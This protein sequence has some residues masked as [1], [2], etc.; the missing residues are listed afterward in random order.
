MDEYSIDINLLGLA[1]EALCKV[2][3]FIAAEKKKKNP[4]TKTQHPDRPSFKAHDLPECYSLAVSAAT[5]RRL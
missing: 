3:G 2:L 4:T 1:Q 5:R